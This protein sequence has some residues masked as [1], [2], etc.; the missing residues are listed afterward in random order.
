[1]SRARWLY[2]EESGEW[3]WAPPPTP[4]CGSS[5][6]EVRTVERTPNIYTDDGRLVDT[7]KHRRR[8]GFSADNR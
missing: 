6:P 2:D 1:M 8:I 7:D 5:D 4:N 3:F